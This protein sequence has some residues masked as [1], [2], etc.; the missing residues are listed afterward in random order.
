LKKHIS[1]TKFLEQ[2][3]L[4]VGSHT[5]RHIYLT[6]GVRP[7]PGWCFLS[8]RLRWTLLPKARYGESF[9]FQSRGGH[10]VL[11]TTVQPSFERTQS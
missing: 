10:S 2:P 5:M 6:I 7:N 4:F 1:L 8:G 9:T 11:W 3:S